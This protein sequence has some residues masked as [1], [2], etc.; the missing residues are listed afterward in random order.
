MSKKNSK[1]W[2]KLSFRAKVLIVVIAVVFIV[3]DISGL[4]FVGLNQQYESEG[5]EVTSTEVAERDKN[6]AQVKR[7]GEIRDSAVAAIRSGNI[8]KANKAYASAIASESDVAYKTE[9]YSDQSQTLYYTGNV[10]E[11]IKIALQAVAALEDKYLLADWLGR[12]YEDQKQYAN[13]AH[14]YTL[15]G[16]W[17]TSPTNEALFDKAYY[18]AQVAR[19]STQEKN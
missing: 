18:D 16:K 9:L 1:R 2:F 12:M 14:Y 10:D 8:A 3:A 4:L 19:V 5:S 7:V 11:A 17:V 13:A 15:A 6:I